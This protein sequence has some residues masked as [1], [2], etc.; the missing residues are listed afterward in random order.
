[1]Q[2]CDGAVE[3]LLRVAI[4]GDGEMHLAEL[5]AG[6]R[7]RQDA[8]VFGCYI[9]ISFG[10]ARRGAEQHREPRREAE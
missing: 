8:V 5:L 6:G 2:N 1:M 4:A 3:A 7:R 10:G 9:P